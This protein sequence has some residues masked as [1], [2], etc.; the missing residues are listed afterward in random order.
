M[1]APQPPSPPVFISVQIVADAEVPSQSLATI[2]AVK[3]HH[4]VMAYRLSHRHGR[5]T[6]FLRLVRLPK[7]TE[8]P[9]Y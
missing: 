5:I 4:I 3:T 7:L 9:M 1:I 8:R 6:D 2:T